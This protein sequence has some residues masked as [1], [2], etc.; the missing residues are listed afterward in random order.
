MKKSQ[1]HLGKNET[2][3]LYYYDESTFS[4]ND[5]KRRYWSGFGTS[6]VLQF[7]N[8][9]LKFKLN[10]IISKKGVASF[11]LSKDSHTKTDVLDFVTCSMA[12]ELK[13]LRFARRLYLVL[14]NSPKNRSKEFIAAAKSS[15]FTLIF[16]TPGSPEENMAEN[17]FFFAKH[18]FATI[19]NLCAINDAKN[20][21]YQLLKTIL[22]CL[23]SV[24]LFDF[25]KVKS[26]YLK[27][28]VKCVD[29]LS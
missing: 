12:R 9:T 23:Q 28:L 5:F 13:S 7:R 18:R 27:E 4:L 10:A 1:S 2:D 16:I 22:A 17:F 15:G 21:Q 26:L 3:Q 14:D 11:Q 24:S 29:R 8:P 6:E 19:K 20:P 25:E